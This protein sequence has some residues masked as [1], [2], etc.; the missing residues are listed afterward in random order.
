MQDPRLYV[1][2]AKFGIVGN[3]SLE[4]EKKNLKMLFHSPTLDFV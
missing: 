3:T 1:I 4:E 2:I